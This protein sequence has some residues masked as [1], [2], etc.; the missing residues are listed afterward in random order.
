MRIFAQ[1]YQGLMS[2]LNSLRPDVGSKVR[3]TITEAFRSV[4]DIL[5]NPEVWE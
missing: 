5:K 4:Q 1:Q 2:S 3:A